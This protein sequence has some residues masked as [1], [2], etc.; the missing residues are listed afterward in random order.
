MWQFNGL[1]MSYLGQNDTIP[2]KKIVSTK[3][4]DKTVKVKWEH[5]KLGFYT[6]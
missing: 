5:S 6:A 3:I 2:K 1:Q 4:F